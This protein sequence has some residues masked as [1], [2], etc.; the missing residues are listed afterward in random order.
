MPRSLL[1]GHADHMLNENRSLWVRAGPRNRV[2]TASRMD[3]FHRDVLQLLRY[4]LKHS[5]AAAPL[6][7]PMFDREQI[8]RLYDIP[9]E[10]R[11]KIWRN[12]DD[13]KYRS[14][15]DRQFLD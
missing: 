8:K 1:A 3:Q 4:S 14:L 7:F 10:T 11:E 5:A 9:I 12:R 15:F 6:L 13:P 2:E